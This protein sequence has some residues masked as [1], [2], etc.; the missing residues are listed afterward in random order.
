M[1]FSIVKWSLSFLFLQIELWIE[2]LRNICNLEYKENR[3]YLSSIKTDKQMSVLIVIKD[4]VRQY[5]VR[6]AHR[7][8]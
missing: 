1:S 5:L 6:Q 2:D 3:T 8:N 7:M 4:Y